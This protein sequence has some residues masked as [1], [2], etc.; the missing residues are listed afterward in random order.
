MIQDRRDIEYYLGVPL[1]AMIPESLTPVERRLRWRSTLACRIGVLL[2]A[3]M[4]P[5]AVLALKHYQILRQIF[6]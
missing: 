4:A 6:R 5:A 3:L 2:L 1:L